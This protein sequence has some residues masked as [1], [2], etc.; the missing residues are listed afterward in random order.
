M[1]TPPNTKKRKFLL[2]SGDKTA[3]NQKE[4][5]WVEG[6]GNMSFNRKAFRRKYE[7]FFMI[8]V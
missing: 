2:L 7:G 8:I 6:N 1:C 3:T 5:L 4:E